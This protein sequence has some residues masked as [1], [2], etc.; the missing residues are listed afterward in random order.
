M[1]SNM[2]VAGLEARRVVVTGLGV[3]SS[4]GFGGREFAESLRV[5]HS[6]VGPIK[7]FDTAGFEHA[8]GCEVVDFDATAWLRRLGVDEVGRASQFSAAAARMAVEDAGLEPSVLEGRTLIAIGT[9]DA[10]SR[11]LD[12]LVQQ[13]L[14]D[15][16]AS[17]D[18][19]R[20]ARVGPGML[21]VSVARELGVR[22]VDVTTIGTACSAGNYAIGAAY[23]AIRLGEAEIGL[24]GGADAMCRKNFT[25]FYR[26][27]T[28][29]PDVCRP[30]DADRQGIL[31]AEGAGVVVL[32]SLESAQARGARI[33][34]EVLGYGLTCDAYH[35]VAP[36]ESSVARCMELALQDAGIEPAEVDFIS[37]HG[38]GT[39]TNDVT[40]SR[41]IRT[42]FG[43]T[44]PPVISLKSMLGHTMGAA[45]AL[46]FIASVI[47]ITD[48]F[49]PPTINHGRT[50][51]ECEIDCVPNRA[52]PQRV[53]VVQ[54]NGLAF[55][56]N[57]ASVIVARYRPAASEMRSP[58][59]DPPPAGAGRHQD[60]EAAVTGCGHDTDS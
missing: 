35:P 32:E 52:R 44:P 40:E 12:E 29:T 23:D 27:G 5:G 43:A 15:G 16:A 1:A 26:L 7:A 33:Y 55:G 30:F 54:N 45:S 56:G 10:E 9:T 46:A 4:I 42:V 3:V 57:N 38:T 51:P 39:K 20:C 22:D 11:D 49:I 8:L 53:D 48:E 37:A 36:K 18:Q 6:R 14:A 34:A 41:A 58:A 28:I 47:A 50:D 13:E 19:R 25:A 60:G 59:V 17:M 2:S 24:S 31:T 21:S